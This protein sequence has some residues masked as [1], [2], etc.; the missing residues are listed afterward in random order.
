MAIA[1]GGCTVSTTEI[2]RTHTHHGPCGVFANALPTPKTMHS[3]R[4]RSIA[5]RHQYD[6][7][8]SSDTDRRR[9]PIQRRTT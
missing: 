4:K 5:N 3:Q 9:G 2:E 8:P 1:S 6:P 7:A